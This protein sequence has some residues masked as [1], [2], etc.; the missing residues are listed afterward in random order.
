MVGRTREPCSLRFGMFGA[1]QIHVSL[2][3]AEGDSAQREVVTQG[4]DSVTLLPTSPNG[5]VVGVDYFYV[6]PH[7]GT[8]GPV[9]IDGNFWDAHGSSAFDGHLAR[10]RVSPPIRQSSSRTMAGHSP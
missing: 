6:K 9:D 7:C 8:D 2:A 10:S 3:R 4:A 5:A 1:P